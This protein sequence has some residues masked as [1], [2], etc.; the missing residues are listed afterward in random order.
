MNNLRQPSLALILFAA[1]C[2]GVWIAYSDPALSIS[3]PAGVASQIHLSW[4]QE[5]STSLTV[6]WH[7]PGS[8]NPAMIEYRSVGATAWLTQ[9]GTTRPSPGRGYLHT[10]TITGLNPDSEYEYRVSDDAGADAPASRIN[11][12]RTAPIDRSSR[13]QFAFISDTGIAGRL[14]GNA[15]GTRQII[16]TIAADHPLFI[17]GGG[18]YAY[19]NFD[20]R[21]PSVGDAIDAWFIQMEPLFSR[22][23][24]MAQYGNHEVSLVEDFA[25]WE[26][27]FALPFGQSAGT[28][29]LY[30]VSQSVEDRLNYSFDVGPA[31]FV[32]LFVPQAFVEPERL[33][34]LDRDLAA[35]RDRGAVWL[36]VY[37]HEPVFGHGYVHPADPRVREALT[38]ILEKHE[39]DIHLSAHDQ[40]YERTF[41]LTGLPD[42]LVI[43]SHALD[44]YR[45]GEGVVY[46][47][48]S[49]SGKMSERQ[50]D[51]SRFTDPMQE[52]MAA[53]NDSL[54][55]YALITING[56]NDLLAEVF[57]VAGDGAPKRRVDSFRIRHRID[58]ADGVESHR[59]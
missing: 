50:S 35:A 1:V 57:G 24:F 12:M 5:P 28:T 6:T 8:D 16:D 25:D 58:A 48:V 18:D 32:G 31:H 55:H 46:M 17:L 47:K 13:Y 11:H 34:W 39:V 30:D 38:P 26:P 42:D 56:E 19:A 43:A 15:N 20:P 40:S 54:H 10:A 29:A 27:R 14:D 44:D 51:F 36:I 23:P 41:P 21:F 9:T 7:T 37:Q 59:D 49:P 45:T 53:R 52:F 2:T 22:V 33:V 4:T 3:S